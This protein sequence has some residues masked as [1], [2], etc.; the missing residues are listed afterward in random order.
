MFELIIMVLFSILH[1]IPYHTANGIYATTGVKLE[2][3][4]IEILGHYGTAP[5]EIQSQCS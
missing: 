1:P 4:Q 3:C 5:A 2:N